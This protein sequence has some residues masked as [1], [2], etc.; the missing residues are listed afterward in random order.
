[1][2][3]IEH[4]PPK[5]GPYETSRD[6]RRRSVDLDRGRVSVLAAS[7]LRARSAGFAPLTTA[8]ENSSGSIESSCGNPA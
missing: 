2:A 5:P 8:R 7:R 3:I 1:M 4:P 6:P